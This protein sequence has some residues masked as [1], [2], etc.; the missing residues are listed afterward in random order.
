MNDEID[1]LVERFLAGAATP[2]EVARLEGYLG[3]DPSLL[4]RFIQDLDQDVSLR[5]LLA[6][7]E[8]RKS[9][10]PSAEQETPR[11]ERSGDR[12]RRRLF[13]PIRPGSPLSLPGGAVA[14]AAV[15]AIVLLLLALGGAGTRREG[16]DDAR[17]RERAWAQKRE[18]A[19]L[20][21]E[22]SA[23]ER[24]SAQAR[25]DELDRERERILPAQ[26]PP[27]RDPES[28]KRQAEDLERLKARRLE[29]EGEMRL[30]AQREARARETF[31]HP[32]TVSVKGRVE[33]EAIY[34]L[35]AAP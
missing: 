19:R 31:E 4:K 16:F 33:P 34:G 13:A 11:S 21:L 32:E 12:P 20:E 2:E 17:R 8:S 15:L 10:S 5:G 14:A 22:Q 7:D 25:L 35:H 18:E 6:W 30:A 9:T 24:R 26:A 28:Q 27:P 23:R 1:L 29:V 3:K